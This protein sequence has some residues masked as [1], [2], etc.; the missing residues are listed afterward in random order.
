MYISL[1]PL[2]YFSKYISQMEQSDRTVTSNGKLISIIYIYQFFLV[3]NELPVQDHRQHQLNKQLSY[4]LRK[5]HILALTT[6]YSILQR[7][8]VEILSSYDL[9]L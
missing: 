3:I 1:D 6:A 9:E 4:L 2:Y 7:H 8:D 5:D